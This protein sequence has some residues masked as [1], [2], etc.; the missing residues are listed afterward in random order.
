MLPSTKGSFIHEDFAGHSGVI[1]GG[2]LQWM[3][4]GRG[5][6]HSEMPMN[7]EVSHGLQLW[8]NLA[9]K[10][11][12]VEPAYQELTKDKVPRVTKDGVTAIVIAG[13]ALGITSPVYTRTPTYYL[14]FQM[15]PGA[16]LRQEIPK[17]WNS[18]I[19]VTHAHSPPL[20]PLTP[21]THSP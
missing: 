14:H 6:V 20:T 4:A 7:R 9:A 16:V 12:M 17:G 5:I 8:V 1:N 2:D 3:T 18:F 19:Y 13:T 11:K 21:H 15:E 10:D